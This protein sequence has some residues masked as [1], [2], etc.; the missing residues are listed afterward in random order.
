M[1]PE[2]KMELAME[3]ITDVLSDFLKN[4]QY[5]AISRVLSAVQDFTNDGFKALEEIKSKHNVNRNK[6]NN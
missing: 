3:L 4:K 6:K 1:T 5:S 2:R